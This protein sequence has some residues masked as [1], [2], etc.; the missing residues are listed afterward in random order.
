MKYNLVLRSRP[1]AQEPIPARH[2]QIMSELA[3]LPSPWGLVSNPWPRAEEP[4]G[5]Y[6][7][8][9]VLKNSFGRS[10]NFAATYRNRAALK[11]EAISD[12]VLDFEFNVKKVDYPQLLESALPR[13]IE[14]TRAYRAD[15]MPYEYRLQEAAQMRLIEQRRNVYNISPVNYF[16]SEISRRA[17]GLSP[18]QLLQ[19]LEGKIAEGRMLGDGAYIVATREIVDADQARQID[20]QLKPLIM[21][22]NVA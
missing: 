15:I 19:R 11:D 12:D 1:S 9:I 3:K 8:A 16:D 4:G 18:Q 14:I 6:I 22:S 17:F 10:I 5:E 7:R 21:G 2:D 20:A 13:Y